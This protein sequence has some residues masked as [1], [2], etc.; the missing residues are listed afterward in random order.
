MQDTGQMAMFAST[1]RQPES[2]WR[3]LEPPSLDGVREVILDCETAGPHGGLRW[4]D[5]ARPIG[6]AVAVRG[7]PRWYLPWGH[8]GGNLPE[9]AVL[10]WARRELRGKRIV[11]LNTRFDIHQMR[12]WGVDLEEQ[13]C[14]FGDVGHYAALLD[15]HRT[16]FSLESIA[17]DYLGQGKLKGLDVSHM[18]EY[19]AGNV[20][21]YATQDV[22]LVDLILDKVRPRL[23]A[24]GLM[25]VAA[26]EDAVIPVV[27]EMEKNAAPLDMELLRR[28]VTE[29]EQRVARCVWEI[30]QDTGLDINPGSTRDLARLFAHLGLRS[31]KYTEKSRPGS[32]KHSYDDEVL[33]S[34]DHP[35][36][37]KARLAKRLISLRQKYLLKYLAEG[38]PLRYALHQLK[39]TGEEG[40]RGGGT[41]SGRFSSSSHGTGYVPDGVN[42]QQVMTPEKQELFGLEEYTVRELYVPEDGL[43]LSADAAQIEY[44]LFASDAQPP[45]VMEAYRRDPWT[46]FHKFVQQVV[47]STVPAMAGITYKNTKDLNFS[48]VYGAGLSKVALMMRVSSEEAAPFV[49]AYDQTFPE[50]ARLIKQVSRL[51]ENRGYIRTPLGRRMRFSR[52]CLCVACSL[53]G[54]RYHK[55]LNGRIQG[56]AADIMKQK[57]VE[58]H[59][60]RRRTG[61]KLRFPVHDE[62]NG[63]VPDVEAAT[64]VVK[65][66]CRQSSPTNVPILWEVGVGRNWKDCKKSREET[67]LDQRIKVESIRAALGDGAGGKGARSRQDEKAQWH[68]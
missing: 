36:I 25:T 58:L 5:G 52:D 16:H 44:R 22:N 60:E 30:Y 12:V 13:G 65:I 56:W 3:P 2:S 26:L 33:R 17:Q 64:E 15:D 35:T 28:W 21:A 51:A 8:A 68:S 40:A 6:I 45:T 61:L 29:S 53:Y 38:S 14:S 63:D 31:S 32:Y 37:R 9:E 23:A 47:R 57:L 4:W 42:I 20:V 41:V 27:C 54:P 1:L 19:H 11:N 50:V 62:V 46:N 39:T 18:A 66:L 10:R 48:K 67:D 43:W 7:G 34:V 59:A 24:E 49:E 55:G